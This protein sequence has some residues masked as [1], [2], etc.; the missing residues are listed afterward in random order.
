MEKQLTFAPRNHQLTNINVWTA[1]S[2]WLVYDVRPSQSSFS[3]LTLERVSLSGEREILYTARDG[4][5]VGVVTA[6]PTLPQRY[7]AIHGPEYPDLR[8]HYDFHH[9]RGVVVQAGIAQTLD[10]CD[11]TPPYTPGA[12]RGGTHV[13]VYSPDG[14]RISF[15]YNDQVMHQLDIKRDLRNVGVAVPLKAV[16]PPK[17][18][19]REYD[20]SH[21]CVLV[22][23]TPP[24]PRAGSDEIDRAYEE[25]WVGLHGY[26]RTDGSRQHS[27]L[28]FIGDTRSAQGEKVAEV[29]I[30]DLPQA[31][32]DFAIAGAQPL[33]GTPAALPAPPAGVM[34]RRLTFT[35]QRRWPGL[36]NQPRHWLRSAPDGSEIAFLMKDDQGIVQLWGIAPSGGEPRQ[37]THSEWSMQSAFSWHPQ[38]GKLAIICDNSVMQVEAESGEMQRLTPRSRLAPVGDAAV[39]S[40]DGRYIAFLRQVDGW[41]QIFIADGR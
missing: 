40:P 8:G 22:S 30:V 17:Q 12:L 25:G 15:T 34:Q 6:S 11:I 21:F 18:H 16:R 23:Q 24:E 10:A 32:A 27:A 14:E 7:L 20:G 26:L 13:H 4:A 38:G 37:I 9:R 36:V 39:W 19:P 31:D 28:A 29:F 3:G 2:Q 33:Q 35:H 41:Q 1:D 5:H